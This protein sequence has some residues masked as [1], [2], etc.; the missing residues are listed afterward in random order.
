[1]NCTLCDTPLKVRADKYYFICSTCGSYLKDQKYYINDEQ[2]KTRYEEHNN[3]VNDPGYQKFTSPITQAVLENFKPA[4]L[5]LDYGCGTGPVIS[6]V[7]KNNGYQVKLYDPYFY[8]DNDYLSHTY[9]YIFSCE[10]FEHFHQPNLELTK[11]ISLLK[12]NGYLLILT[13][14]FD[15]KI[16]FGSWYYRN[17]QTHVFIYTANTIQYIAEN[18]P[19]TIEKTSE[20]L[21]IFK[22][23][24]HHK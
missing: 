16:N 1:M 24:D 9:D 20:R 7:L 3:D 11:L 5:G 13:H 23:T 18:Y 15:P 19:L 14:L 6:K 8:S 17:D 12:P 4:H 2:E 10:V 21:T 22:K